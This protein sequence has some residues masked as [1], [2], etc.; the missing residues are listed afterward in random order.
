MITTNVIRRV[1]YLKVGKSTGTG[2]ALNHEGKQYLITAGHLLEGMT[3]LDEIQSFH[4][5]QWKGLPSAMVGIA[6]NAD[7]AVLAP[8]IELAPSLPLEAT[9]EGI[10][11]GQQVFFLRVSPRDDVGWRPNEPRFSVSFGQV[12]STQRN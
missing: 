5:D 4:E 1:F 10:Q 6:Q 7:T 9:M 2:F 3:S 8:G 12:R 11:F